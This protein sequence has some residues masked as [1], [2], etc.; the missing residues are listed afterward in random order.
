M[1]K[2]ILLF[3]FM[4][5]PTLCAMGN[6]EKLEPSQWR[7][8]K[9]KYLL[10]ESHEQA[11]SAFNQEI[12][13]CKQAFVRKYMQKYEQQEEI[14]K[15]LS[16]KTHGV[17]RATGDQKRAQEDKNTFLCWDPLEHTAAEIDE[18][19]ERIEQVEA[20]NED[21]KSKTWMHCDLYFLPLSELKI[22]GFDERLQRSLQEYE[23]F[24]MRLEELS[25]ITYGRIAA[26]TDRQEAEADYD[27][28]M[29]HDVM[30]LT[31]DC[32]NVTAGSLEFRYKEYLKR[33][34]MKD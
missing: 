13:S 25:R 2:I 8:R 21:L 33:M 23:R 28:F 11:S 29:I 5:A 12:R 17:V 16:K 15:D 9:L 3:L 6:P 18:R 4:Y 30:T 34:N 19:G 20:E 24:K 26:T 10:E 31:P 27:K 32:I 1:V 7:T 14:L 22:G